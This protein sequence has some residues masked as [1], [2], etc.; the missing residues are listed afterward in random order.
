MLDLD[1]GEVRLTVKE[2]IEKRNISKTKVTQRAFLQSHQLNNYYFRRIQR[3]DLA[4]L[5]RLCYVLD[6]TIPDLLVYV[7]PESKEEEK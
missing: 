5:A 4:V 3:P 7:P 1:F 6:C 2:V